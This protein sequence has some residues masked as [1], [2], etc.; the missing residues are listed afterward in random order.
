LNLEKR[1]NHG[2]HGARGEMGQA[3]MGDKS[4]NSQSEGFQGIIPCWQANLEFQKIPV[5]NIRF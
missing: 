2:E 1:L 4:P 5:V 3:G